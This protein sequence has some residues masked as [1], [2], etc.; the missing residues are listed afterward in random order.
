MPDPAFVAK[1]ES[2]MAEIGDERTVSGK[3]DQFAIW[4]GTEILGFDLGL[5]AERLHVGGSGDEKIDLGVAEDDVPI[6]IIAQCKYSVGGTG[7]FN[8]DQV[9][10]VLTARRRAIEYPTLG[11]TARQEFCKRYHSAKQKPERLLCVGFGG[12]VEEAFDYATGNNVVVYD[13]DRIWKE[14]LSRR[15][16]ARLP[17]PKLVTIPASR[18]AVIARGSSPRRTLVTSLSTKT[19]HEIIKQ[20]GLGLFSENF[21]Y[22]LPS[23]ARSDAISEAIKK[24]LESQAERLLERN[25]GLTFVGERVDWKS[26]AID[27]VDPQIVNGCQ[28]SYAIHE[29]YDQRIRAGQVIEELPGGELAI[30]VV[31]TTD[32]EEARKIA[33]ATNRQN[34][35]TSRD[36]RA[37]FDEQK[38]LSD[39]F[40]G[41]SPRVFF[42]TREGAWSAIEARHETGL[43]Q[44]PGLSRFRRLHNEYAGQIMLALYGFPHWSKDRKKVIM[45]DDEIYRAIFEIEEDPDVRFANIR[46]ASPIPAFLDT[47]AK[48]PVHFVDDVLFGFAVAQYLDAIRL[49][50]WP[51]KKALWPDPSADPIGRMV[52]GKEFLDYWDLHVCALVNFLV[53]TLSRGDRGKMQR[54]RRALIGDDLNI[55]FSTPVKRAARFKL[56]EDRTIHELLKAELAD[57]TTLG[58]FSRWINSVDAIFSSVLETAQARGEFKNLNQFFYKREK[59][60]EEARDKASRWLGSTVERDLYFPLPTGI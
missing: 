58:H 3:G 29:W 34:P 15:D 39:A 36:L 9:E 22:K 44:I 60:F 1:V 30:K 28:T 43:Y 53:V 13:L 12:F 8:K 21:R 24:T 26:D 55:P 10:E 54:I 59:T 17:K 48:G 6:R 4:F 50:M 51:K 46:A 33:E 2:Q 16:P 52:L 40:N 23:S 47:V 45:D 19:L 49:R 35:I 18:D 38:E 11:S 31:E 25:N 56:S 7:T 41:L 57:T 42:E 20:H 5:V 37:N 27:I 14:W 32:P